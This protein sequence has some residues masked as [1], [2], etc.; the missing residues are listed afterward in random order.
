MHRITKCTDIDHRYIEMTKWSEKQFPCILR[1][2][3]NNLEPTI[4]QCWSACH[5]QS[6]QHLLF[7]VDSTGMFS[8]VRVS[9]W[10][11]LPSVRRCICRSWSRSVENCH[12]LVIVIIVIQWFQFKFVIR[13]CNQSILS[14]FAQLSMFPDTTKWDVNKDDHSN[15]SKYNKSSI[16]DI[17]VSVEKFFSAIQVAP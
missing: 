13:C 10:P 2:D 3:H 8:I 6:V 12:I 15:G 5:E 4:S 7:N 1:Q 14:T 17:S 16:N 9:L 11:M